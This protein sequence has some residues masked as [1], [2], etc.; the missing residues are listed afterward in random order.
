MAMAVAA[1]AVPRS[2]VVA[3]ALTILGTVVL[4]GLGLWQLQRLAWK[5]NLVAMVEA[6]AQAPAVPVP[7]EADWPALTRDSDEYRKVTLVGRFDHGHEVQV[8]T[9]LQDD[10][11]EVSGP[12]WWVMTPLR[13]DSGAIV[14]VNRG[15]VPHA[16]RDPATRAAGQLA[17]EVEITG[18]LRLPE[19]GN[20]FTPDNQPGTR[21]WYVRD[22][23]AI[24]AAERLDRVA[25]FFVDADST[26]NPG[27]LPLGGATRVAFRNDHLGYAITWFG[28]AV[29]LVGVYLAWAWSQIRGARILAAGSARQ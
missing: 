29:A 2:V 25:P 24:A 11:F 20:I 5:Q 21:T 27:G 8:F 4:C 16:F 3:G 14:F 15:F 17:G 1:R 9:S 19:A 10:R 12:G 13:L 18:L 23:Q 28:L 26:P 7:A 6:R 22:P